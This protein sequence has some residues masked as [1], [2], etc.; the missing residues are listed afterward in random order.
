MSA[1][2]SNF[3]LHYYIYDKCVCVCVCNNIVVYY[4][5]TILLPS[6]FFFFSSFYDHAAQ[7]LWLFTLTFTILYIKIVI[8]LFVYKPK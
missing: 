5:C 2:E 7:I 6:G 8:K 3:T 1:D 4:S